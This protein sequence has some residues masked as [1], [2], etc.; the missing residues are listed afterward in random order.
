LRHATPLTTNDYYADL[1]DQEEIME[2]WSA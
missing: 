1:I 2:L